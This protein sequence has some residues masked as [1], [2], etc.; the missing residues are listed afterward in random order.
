MAFLRDQPDKST[1][2]AYFT[3]PYAAKSGTIIG[4]PCAGCGHSLL[5][6]QEAHNWSVTTRFSAALRLL[7][8]THFSGSVAP[9]PS[10]SCFRA[11]HGVVCG[12]PSVK[13]AQQYPTELQ[14]M[15]K[16]F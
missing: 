7:P 16:I 14:R 1:S 9:L 15:F 3:S 2:K 13:A 12:T 4:S 8:R 5:T 6:W 11:M 10:G